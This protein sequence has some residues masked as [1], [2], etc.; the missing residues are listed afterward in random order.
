MEKKAPGILDPD[1][2]SGIG[3]SCFEPN[4]THF[5]HSYNL[6]CLEWSRKSWMLCD[7]SLVMSSSMF[8]A[9]TCYKLVTLLD[10]TLAFVHLELHFII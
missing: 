2:L 6:W 4:M 10:I 9:G 8:D 3:G 7:P 1:A 5:C